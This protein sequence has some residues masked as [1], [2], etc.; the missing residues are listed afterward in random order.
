MVQ[1]MGRFFEGKIDEFAVAHDPEPSKDGDL[2]D[3]RRKA[4]RASRE[5]NY[6]VEPASGAHYFHNYARL[7]RWILPALR[8]A[9]LGTL[10]AAVTIW[11]QSFK[12]RSRA[13]RKRRCRGAT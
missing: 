12:R 4:W 13:G 5:Q 9:Y 10:S 7:R 1:W 3:R 11:W 8:Q 6:S 2:Y